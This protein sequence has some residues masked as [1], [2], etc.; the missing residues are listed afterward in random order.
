VIIIIEIAA[1]E[2]DASARCTGPDHRCDAMKNIRLTCRARAVRA[3]AEPSPSHG[4]PASVVRSSTM[5]ITAVTSSASG[6]LG[7]NGCSWCRG[8]RLPGDRESTQCM[9]HPAK[10]GCPARAGTPNG[11]GA[12]R[13]VDA[14]ALDRWAVEAPIQSRFAGR[15]PRR[16]QPT[17]WARSGARAALLQ[18]AP[19]RTRRAGTSAP[20]DPRPPRSTLERPSPAS[21]RTRRLRHR[22]SR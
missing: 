12:D 20:P 22:R 1:R 15:R 10:R 13:K 14:V 8:P 2:A 18:G 19:C 5:P 3:E 17:A 16:T 9:V 11:S 4:A 7:G 6:A 21:A